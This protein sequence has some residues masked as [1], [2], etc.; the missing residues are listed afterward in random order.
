MITLSFDESLILSRSF[1]VKIKRDNHKYYGKMLLT[2]K[3][4]LVY[5]KSLLGKLQVT[6]YSYS[7]LLSMKYVGFFR[8]KL[9]LFISD[10]KSKDNAVIIFILEDEDEVKNAL[11]K[12]IREVKIYNIE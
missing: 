7:S 11:K 4:I 5:R 6:S 3:R 1:D 2:T 10:N 12:V 8:K 9:A